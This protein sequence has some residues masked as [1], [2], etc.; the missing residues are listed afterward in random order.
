MSDDSAKRLKARAEWIDA[1]KAGIEDEE[2]HLDQDGVSLSQYRRMGDLSFDDLSAEERA[3]VI[4]R[5]EA[6]RSDI[7]AGKGFVLDDAYLSR[8]KN[9]AP[10]RQ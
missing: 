1:A 3:E 4:E 6:G 10:S 7:A 5:L 9:R 2:R 8:L